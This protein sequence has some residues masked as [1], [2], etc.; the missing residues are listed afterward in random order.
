MGNIARPF[1]LIRRKG[2]REKR[3]GR[4]RGKRGSEGGKEAKDTTLG[5]F[6]K[7]SGGAYRVPGIPTKARAEDAPAPTWPSPGAQAA[8]D[9]AGGGANVPNG[10]S[11]PA[12]PASLPA[13]LR[14]PAALPLPTKPISR[15]RNEKKNAFCVRF[16]H[17]LGDRSWRKTKTKIKTKVA[18]Q[19]VELFRP[20][21]LRCGF[22]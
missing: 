4:E 14:S 16:Y 12:L 3:E 18:R 5:L 19:V 10:P 13:A 17:D 1:L 6:A 7:I 9:R 15:F 11:P 2:E 21:S 8:R 20:P 22:E